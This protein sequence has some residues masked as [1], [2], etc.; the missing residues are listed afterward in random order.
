MGVKRQF[1]EIGFLLPSWSWGVTL[2]L[3]SVTAHAFLYLQRH[4]LRLLGLLITFPLSVCVYMG[5]GRGRH[6]TMSMEVRGRFVTPF[7]PS[8]VWVGR[9]MELRVIGLGGKLLYTLSHL[10]GPIRPGC[11]EILSDSRDKARP[12]RMHL[13]RAGGSH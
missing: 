2:R 8:T 5:L 9:G 3:L 13:P 7:S 1:A 12:L 6:A 10:A 4:L 11:L